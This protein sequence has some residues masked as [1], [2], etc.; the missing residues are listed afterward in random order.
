MGI[1]MR[2]YLADLYGTPIRTRIG[3]NGR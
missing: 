2:G 1:D 3:A